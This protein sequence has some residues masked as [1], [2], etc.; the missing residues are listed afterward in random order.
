[1]AAQSQGY[2]VWWFYRRF[3]TYACQPGSQPQVC[4][5]MANVENYSVYQ[6]LARSLSIP[7]NPFKIST[8]SLYKASHCGMQLSGSDD[9]LAE[10]QQGLEVMAAQLGAAAELK[11]FRKMGPRLHHVPRRRRTV[12]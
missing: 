4:L 7:S 2:I 9:F 3:K 6:I 11:D 8:K 5:K 1:M 10:V 12:L